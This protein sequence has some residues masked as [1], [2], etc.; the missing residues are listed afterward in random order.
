MAL[1]KRNKRGEANRIRIA[2][3]ARKTAQARSA[4]NAMR[5]CIRTTVPELLAD[6]DDRLSKN[7]K[8]G[9]RWSS[10]HT[11]SANNEITTQELEQTAIAFESLSDKGEKSVF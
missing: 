4:E 10:E 1:E 2:N 3:L 11:N 8:F 6:W 5:S 7:Q 9:T